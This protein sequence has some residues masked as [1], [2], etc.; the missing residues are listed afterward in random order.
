MRRS[1]TMSISFENVVSTVGGR[2]R[3][4]SLRCYWRSN[5]ALVS[6]TGFHAGSHG[7]KPSGLD[8]TGLEGAADGPTTTPVAQIMVRFEMVRRFRV[9]TKTWVK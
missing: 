6:R 7:T 1:G 3:M 4:E 9:S 2:S 8:W 5:G